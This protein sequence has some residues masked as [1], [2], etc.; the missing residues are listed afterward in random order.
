VHGVGFVSLYARVNTSAPI[1][2]KLGF[3]KLNPM[4]EFEKAQK[5]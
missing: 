5:V 4:I 2:A 3:K 1:V